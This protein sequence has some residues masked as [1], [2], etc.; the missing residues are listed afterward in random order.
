MRGQHWTPVNSHALLD[1]EGGDAAAPR[2][3]LGLGVDHQHLGVGPVGD[4]HL[5][6]VEDVAVALAYRA[7]AHPHHVRARARLAH[8]KRADMLAGDQPGQVAAA[9]L[10][11][12]STG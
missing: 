6:A 10:G 12:A 1:E 11:R 9:L 4:P 3:G 7:R 5:G 2:I 8:G